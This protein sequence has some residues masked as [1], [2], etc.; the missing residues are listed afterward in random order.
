MLLGVEPGAVPGQAVVD[1]GPGDGVVLYTD[2]ITEADRHRPLLPAQLAEELAPLHGETAA[3]VARHVVGLAEER[4]GGAL[5]D[6]LA[7]LVARTTP[8]DG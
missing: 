5:R 3:S 7:V 6:D 4:A 2:G 8:A 1:L